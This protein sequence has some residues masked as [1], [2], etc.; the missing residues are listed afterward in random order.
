MRTSS[1]VFAGSV[2]VSVLAALQGAVMPPQ[3]GPRAGDSRATPDQAASF[4]LAVAAVDRAV[5][6]VGGAS[7]L[8]EYGQLRITLEGASA[9]AVQGHD[10]ADVDTPKADGRFT[11]VNRFDERAV[12]YY[13]ETRQDVSGGLHLRLGTLVR[14]GTQYALSFEAKRL[15]RSTGPSASPDALVQTTAR[16]V[17]GLLLRRALENRPSLRHEGDQLVDGAPADRVSF[18]WD[19]RTR[20][21]TAVRRSDG[22]LLWLTAVG[23]DPLDGES[24]STYRYAEYQDAGRPFQPSRIVLERRGTAALDLRVTEFAVGPASTRDE[25]FQVPQGLADQPSSA[26]AVRA[27]APGVHE[28]AGLGGGLY[29]TQFFDTQAGVVVFDAPL[30]YPVAQQVIR[31]IEKTLPGRAIVTVVISHFH[32]DHAGGVA[33]FVDIGANV[34]TTRETAPVLERYMRAQRGQRPAARIARFTFVDREPVRVGTS[35]GGALDVHRLSTP[36]VKDMLVLIDATSGS[37]VQGDLYSDLST[38]NDTF[39]QFA[40][41]LEPHRGRLTRLLGTHHDELSVEEFLRMS[42][43]YRRSSQRGQE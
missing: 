16:F 39:A 2:F 12:R 32:A 15:T 14:D 34:V 42:S 41:W 11:A 38:F 8:A 4:R 6:A 7:R 40:L 37:V 29:R 27:V 18:S 25:D 24:E 17:P 19:A 21:V 5:A 31:T 20:Y 13:Q 3:S 23:P 10:P 28:I 33:A 22:R 43:A 36:H 35:G 9:N 30:G 26:P 1:F